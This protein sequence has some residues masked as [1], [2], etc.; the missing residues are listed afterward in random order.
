MHTKK[1]PQIRNRQLVLQA[2]IAIAS[3]ATTSCGKQEGSL[4]ANKPNKCILSTVSTKPR[5]KIEFDE[6]NGVLKGT[7]FADN[8][9]T[10]SVLLSCSNG[11]GFC[12]VDGQPIIGINGNQK[13][14]EIRKRPDSYLMPAI[15]KDSIWTKNKFCDG[16]LRL[17]Y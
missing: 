12:Y 14:R 5:L 4:I 15:S 2:L 11:S 9:I 6:W 7:L 8:R 1:R 16:V 10:R 3:V 17:V 13:S